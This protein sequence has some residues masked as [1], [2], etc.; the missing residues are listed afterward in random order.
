MWKSLLRD[1]EFFGD[2]VSRNRDG[3]VRINTDEAVKIIALTYS[4]RVRKAFPDAWD[5]A[6]VLKDELSDSVDKFINV[7]RRPSFK[8]SQLQGEYAVS[9]AIFPWAWGVRTDATL[10]CWQGAFAV[11]VPPIRF[12]DRS[13]DTESGKGQITESDVVAVL[14][15]H[16]QID[17]IWNANKLT[18]G[19]NPESAPERKCMGTCLCW[20]RGIFFCPPEA[21]HYK[22]RCC[23]ATATPK[24]S[25]PAAAAPHLNPVKING[26]GIGSVSLWP[27]EG[28]RLDGDGLSDTS[29]SVTDDRGVEEDGYSDLSVDSDS[30]G[31]TRPWNTF[32]EMDC[33]R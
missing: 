12:K 24:G 32:S 29:D 3:Y 20:R 11:K 15:K 19:C 25:A 13:W 23:R 27:Y 22:G 2:I 5:P 8:P 21:C 26:G 7:I 16:C 31:E 28:G 33:D 6:S 30:D 18:C 1:Q 17:A 9:N 10:E 14:S 4:Y